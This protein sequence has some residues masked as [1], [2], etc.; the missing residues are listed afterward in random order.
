MMGLWATSI[1]GLPWDP[2]GIAGGSKPLDTA[3]NERDDKGVGGLQQ[4]GGSNS[5]LTTHVMEEAETKKQ[6][7]TLQGR[8]A[9]R[10][11]RQNGITQATAN[12]EEDRSSEAAANSTQKSVRNKSHHSPQELGASDIGAPKI[13]VQLKELSFSLGD[14]TKALSCLFRDHVNTDTSP[15]PGKSVFRRWNPLH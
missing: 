8:D 12:S 13:L 1:Y 3:S 7:E 10:G 9:G 15:F 6:K 2:A 4:D 5:E 11:G 14:H